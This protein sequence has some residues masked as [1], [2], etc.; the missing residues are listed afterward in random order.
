MMRFIL[1]LAI[2]FGFFGFGQVKPLTPEDVPEEVKKVVDSNSLTFVV[3]KQ[4]EFPGGLSEFKKKFTDNFDTLSL[5]DSING[6]VK[7]TIYF[8]VENDGSVN[9]IKAV[10]NNEHFNREAEK[11]VK[12]INTKYEPA[13]VNNT[14]VRYLMR[15]PLSM[16][17]K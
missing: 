4:P 6:A 10:G 1:L 9:R 14:P 17:F 7:T 16:N 13:S 11:A 12:A 2:F 15:F 5:K 8:V 3:M